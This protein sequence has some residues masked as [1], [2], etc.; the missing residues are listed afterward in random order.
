MFF[1]NSTILHEIFLQLIIMP[2]VFD[3]HNS[4]LIIEGFLKDV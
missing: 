2:F 3:W 1:L 4:K